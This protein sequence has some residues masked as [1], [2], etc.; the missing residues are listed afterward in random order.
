MIRLVSACTFLI[1]GSY[2][3]ESYRRMDKGME[4]CQEILQR[5]DLPERCQG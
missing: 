3:E 2:Q 4:I 5:R 1:S